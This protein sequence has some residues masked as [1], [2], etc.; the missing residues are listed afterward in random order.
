[1]LTTRSEDVRFFGN[2]VV[3]T[4]PVILSGPTRSAADE[5]AQSFQ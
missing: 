4:I 5:L 3:Y 1:V 2:G